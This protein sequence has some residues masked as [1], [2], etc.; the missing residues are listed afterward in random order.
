MREILRKL[1]KNNRKGFTLAELLI[2]IAITGILATFGFVEV[3]KAQ[4]KLKRTEMD[5][6]AREIFVAAQ[7]HLTSSQT[8]GIWN[9]SYVKNDGSINI[10]T[11]EWQNAVDY[12]FTDYSEDAS[13]YSTAQTDTKTH[14]FYDVIY[15]KTTYAEAL[16]NSN[17][18]LQ[19]LLPY[20]SIDDTVRTEGSY[21]IEF[22]AKTN[23]IYGVFYTDKGVITSDDLYNLNTSRQDATSREQFSLTDSTNSSKKISTAMGYYGG[24]K[25]Y[26]NEVN[27]L[28]NPVVQ[29]FNDGVDIDGNQPN[30][31]TL[32]NTNALEAVITDPNYVAGTKQTILTITISQKSGTGIKPANATFTIASPSSAANS[33][34]SLS[35]NRTEG[36]P[37][38]NVTENYLKN[39][40]STKVSSTGG[41]EY[42]IS[43]D[44]ITGNF[45][46]FT[47]LFPTFTPGT[48][49]TVEATVHY[50]GQADVF[51]VS[52]NANSLFDGTLKD[53]SST[54][55]ISTSATGYYSADIRTA[56]HLQNLSQD[57]SNYKGDLNKFAIVG[58]KLIN[59]IDWKFYTD[60]ISEDVTLS[61]GTKTSKKFQSIYNETLSYFD[62]KRT[63]N[64]ANVNYILSTFD[65]KPKLD[66]SG[67]FSTIDKSPL[68]VSNMD[69]VDFNVS[70]TSFVGT[71]IGKVEKETTIEN[72][73]VYNSSDN[74]S[75]NT[76][77][78]ADT[79]YYGIKSLYNNAGGLIG[80]SASTL[81]I[82]DSSSSVK[83]NADKGIA[84]G[85]VGNITGGTLKIS[86]S[87][88]GGKV[89]N[90][91]EYDTSN[92]A[93]NIYGT[94]A[95]GII[96]S[97]GSA[98]TASIDSVY[99]TAS[100]YGSMNAGGFVGKIT[101]VLNASNVYI[102]APVNGE[103]IK[104]IF[105][106]SLTRNMLT[107][108][109]GSLR[110]LN[111]VANAIISSPYGSGRTNSATVY[112][113]S[114]SDLKTNSTSV[115]AVSYTSLGTV[116]PYSSALKTHYGDWV[117]EAKSNTTLV[118]NI[119]FDQTVDN[120]AE[121]K[122]IVNNTKF[123]AYVAYYGN[124]YY[125]N[126]YS[127]KDSTC[128]PNSTNDGYA[129]ELKITDLEPGYN[130]IF[131][132]NTD[133]SSLQSRY[134]QLS[135]RNYFNTSW[136]YSYSGWS[137]N[138]P[139]S[140]S[141]ADYGTITDACYI[142]NSSQ[143][144]TFT[145]NNHYKLK[146]GQSG[147]LYYEKY[148]D[149]TYKLHG[150]SSDG[151]EIGDGNY[152]TSASTDIVE[153]GYVLAVNDGFYENGNLGVE[154]I[155]LVLAY[156]DGQYW[157]GN[158]NTLSDL[159]DSTNT[160]K[161]IPVDDGETTSMGLAGSHVYKLNLDSS[162]LTNI[163]ADGK[164]YIKVADGNSYNAEVIGSYTMN[165][166]F[167]D[168]V[169]QVSSYSDGGDTNHRLRTN[170]QLNRILEKGGTNI[171]NGWFSTSAVIDQEMDIDMSTYYAAHLNTSSA[172]YLSGIDRGLTYQG[173]VVTLD[174]GT[175]RNAKLSGIKNTFIDNLNGG[176]V[177]NL[178]V[179]L[180]VGKLTDIQTKQIQNEDKYGMF[181]SNLIS[182]NF[183]NVEFVDSNI[184][185]LTINKSSEV[186]GIIG[187]VNSGDA[188]VSD[189]SFHNIN[190]V[191]ANITAKSFGL[192]GEQCVDL[193]GFTADG[194]TWKSST[195]NATNCGLIGY[196]FYNINLSDAK[197][198]NIT[199]DTLTLGNGSYGLI[200][201]I[202]TGT[203][204]LNGIQAKMIHWKTI[205]GTPT[206]LGL[207]A[208]SVGSNV[209]DADKQSAMSIE[210]VAFSDMTVT[211]DHF[212]LFG[213]YEGSSN[214]LT[215]S[216]VTWENLNITPASSSWKTYSSYPLNV[217]SNVTLIP[218]IAPGQIFNTTS[219]SN[220]TVHNLND[221]ATFTGIIGNVYGNLY[222]TNISDIHMYND[223]NLKYQ[224]NG[225]FCGLIGRVGN[226]GTTTN[227]GIV[228]GLQITKGNQ[229]GFAM[230]NLA[231]NTKYW[232]VIGL[233]SGLIYNNKF[234]DVAINNIDSTGAAST[235]V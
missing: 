137:G 162:L 126:T 139:Y 206:Y 141:R 152:S 40:I 128:T 25:A 28:K 66:V 12:A 154:Q 21:V 24:A 50:G 20:G 120:E 155:N 1:Q 77:G 19:L 224:I 182:G 26:Q 158:G 172:Y 17:S 88:V 112:S 49:I 122:F 42:H 48:D 156:N 113:A 222:N 9:A 157:W 64:S 213:R 51:A 207:I 23:S 106:G 167:A 90:K 219:I 79:G 67:L 199:W 231:L 61:D 170:T 38:A 149:G 166:Y 18:V 161:M 14:A 78:E 85:L 135:S 22:D 147:L 186:V 46:H 39:V 153:D 145:F 168:S 225:Q 193:S 34:G 89:K 110:Y 75:S 164:S 227:D 15:N 130:Y 13:V 176:T 101:N 83:V 107:S 221:K 114:F 215:I 29:V 123:D 226:K 144:T 4:R 189:V 188:V 220:V 99:S 118:K 73:H 185:D 138:W 32:N 140:I 84:G 63:D 173:G 47:N 27:H 92:E 60:S 59:N 184:T 96:G 97:F 103:N 191:N 104:G 234:N 217:N 80:E 171:T 95:G 121:K 196:A 230:E 194:V 44:D 5:N 211:T 45:R 214:G 86:S 116:Y 3:T 62:G 218:V 55:I 109:N 192:I 93:M 36:Y 7:N 232:G 223:A 102:A 43:L 10:K 200:G 208:N 136:N 216:G 183:S 228:N 205:T 143:K 57:I 235:S 100:V 178:I 91:T 179:S 125:Y 175:T 52:K 195:I 187:Y 134:L 146:Q 165:P 41:I 129:C 31:I 68:S 203:T 201:T 212:G 133:N 82:S 98:N 16:T 119:Y 70:G 131:E 87:Y 209:I 148:A 8:N 6:T 108:S 56:R 177:R 105:V 202:A 37:F 151:N 142:W 115:A 71:L 181:L 76:Y 174:D 58:A 163:R 65:V 81:T 169:K 2:V 124:W 159:M 150:Y 69:L 74:G 35:F 210:D 197:F 72:V 229:Y 190:F 198:L 53:V 94:T 111:S 160:E 233:N 117:T 180:D 132:E 127:L 204:K 30:G 54:N 11:S 33:E